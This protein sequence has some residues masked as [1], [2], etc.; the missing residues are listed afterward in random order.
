MA[1]DKFDKILAG[2]QDAEKEQL[3]QLSQE[4]PYS[5]LVQKIKEKSDQVNIH[6]IMRYDWS[7]NDGADIETPDDIINIDTIELTSPK[8]KPRTSK[9]KQKK[10]TSTKKTT[11]IKADK[12]VEKAVTKEKRIT[13][14]KTTKAKATAGS[15]TAPKKK[16]V[17]SKSAAAPKSKQADATPS[18]K[19]TRTTG[20]KAKSQKQD[21]VVLDE[22][23]LWLNSLSADNSA[24]VDTKEKK[25]TEVKETI[26]PPKAKS[27]KTP[28][29]VKKKDDI[30]DMIDDSIKSKENIATESLAKL[31]EQQGY[32]D[33]AIEVY[34]NL[35]LK[36]PEKSS[37]FAAQIKKLKDKI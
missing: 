14:K 36:N 26:K 13:K 5:I 4:A 18:I 12:E 28:K 25:G 15:K 33:K 37:F 27:S 35:R 30:K 31:Y 24:P 11:Q 6:A 22:F 7:S 16:V 32:F 34:E 20:T 19:K 1:E 23:T 9:P 8:K 21:R 10:A 3:E 29:R 17:S 2:K